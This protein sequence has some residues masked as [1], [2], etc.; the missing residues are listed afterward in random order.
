[1][2]HQDPQPK[3]QSPL[4]FAV[5][6]AGISGL[7]A[8]TAIANHSHPVTVFDKGRGPGG[9]MSTRR[10]GQLRFDHGA[11]YFTAKDPVFA[12][13]VAE[14]RR[15]GLV[16]P[17]NPRLAEINPDGFK[18]KSGGPD[19]FVG[20]PAMNAICKHLAQSLR[21]PSQVRCAIKVDS[22]RRTDQRWQLLQDGGKPL[23]EF[24]R[25]IIA[26]PPAQAAALMADAAPHLATQASQA[27]LEPCWAA[28]LA[29]EKPLFDG[30]PE[31]AIDGAFVNTGPLSWIARDSAKPGREPGE[32]WIAHAG[33][34]W[35]KANLELDRQSAAELLKQAFFE[36]VSA[37]PHARPAAPTL[38]IAHRWRY[39]LPSKPIEER[40]LFDAM[41]GLACCGD[42]C[43][44]PRVEGAFLSGVASAGRVIP[45]AQTV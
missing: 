4:T 31:T 44:G 45:P 17:W 30:P 12:Q 16:K 5:I 10:E 20:V 24:D 2:T 39:A 13:A 11:Q 41:L 6:G 19:R 7:T 40:C 8:A 38:C 33:P 28:M 29:F 14:W 27:V 23:G 35:S 36:V 34:A 42:W 21:Q 22:I 1:M 32:R 9:R 26:A 43:A 3:L 37:I 25:L 15:Q 18:M